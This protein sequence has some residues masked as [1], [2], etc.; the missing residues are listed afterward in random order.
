MSCPGLSGRWIIERSDQIYEAVFNL[1]STKQHQNVCPRS[2]CRQ[3]RCIFRDQLHLARL[4]DLLQ[5]LLKCA[6][7]RICELRVPAVEEGKKGNEPTC[8]GD[9]TDVDPNEWS[10]PDK[11]RLFLAVGKIFQLPFP[12]YQVR[13]IHL[14]RQ[15]CNECLYLD[16]TYI[17][18]IARF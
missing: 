4:E 16:T 9:Q 1:R 10:Q 8:S 14:L 13:K 2:L 12:F 17:I 5:R 6:V 3:C 18:F 7:D 11:E 15:V